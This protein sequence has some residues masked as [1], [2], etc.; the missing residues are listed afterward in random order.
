MY[1]YVLVTHL[2]GISV[3][4]KQN[5]HEKSSTSRKIINFTKNHQL[6]LPHTYMYVIIRSRS[7]A[8]IFFLDLGMV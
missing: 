5:I 1:M 2:N 6:Q 3:A 8:F 4:G 7:S